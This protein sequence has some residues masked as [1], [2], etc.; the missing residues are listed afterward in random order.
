M[1]FDD[2]DPL[3]VFDDWYVL[4]A[5]ILLDEILLINVVSILKHW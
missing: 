1:S 5:L 3:D 4:A 2:F